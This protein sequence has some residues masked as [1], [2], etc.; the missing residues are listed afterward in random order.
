MYG[1]CGSSIVASGM[2]GEERQTKEVADGKW[3]CTGRNVVL[4]GWRPLRA[5]DRMKINARYY[6]MGEGFIV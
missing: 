3:R 6:G 4:A 2:G 1:R 5:K